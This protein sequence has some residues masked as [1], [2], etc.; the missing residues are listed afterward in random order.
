[1]DDPPRNLEFDAYFPDEWG[2]PYL[3][4]P[5][6]GIHL[7]RFTRIF[8]KPTSGTVPQEITYPEAIQRKIDPGNS[9]IVSELVSESYRTDLLNPLD[10]A[11]QSLRPPQFPPLRFPAADIAKQASG[12]KSTYYVYITS[13]LPASVRAGAKLPQPVEVVLWFG[14][15]TEMNRHGLRTFFE[16]LTV[17]TAFVQIPGIEAKASDSFGRQ[18]AIGITSEQIQEL[19]NATFRGVLP[20]PLPSPAASGVQ[21]ISF[22]IK[23]IYAFSTG[24][25]GF[26]LTVRNQLI[27]L[28]DIQRAVMVDC[29]YS[30]GGT[31][32]AALDMIRAATKGAVKIVTYVASGDGTPGAY[33]GQLAVNV[34]DRGVSWLT[35]NTAVAYQTL[36]HARVLNS[37][38]EDQILTWSSIAP[39][40]QPKLRALFAALPARGTVISDAAVYAFA[41]GSAPPNGA[42]LLAEWFAKIPA[43][44][45]SA[46]WQA[47][48][49]DN[50]NYPALVRLIWANQLPGWSNDAD[51]TR[52]I[53]DK[54]TALNA[55]YH[56]FLPFEFAWECL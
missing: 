35:R 10:P 45:R 9:E 42:V 46:F 28:T 32:Q 8:L 43:E 2:A 5:K 19:L 13:V 54:P 37:G 23:A 27:P 31:T 18:W 50:G 21:P 12:R 52:R 39:S 14:V 20:P 30:D 44:V 15:G 36:T 49:N 55:G 4:P 3:T 41:H 1:M 34:P 53:P 25:L 47:L 22:K 24:H 26:G 29:L 33:T 48:W 6:V 56:D 38:F 11:N 7:N 51:P 16:H 17:P 40:F